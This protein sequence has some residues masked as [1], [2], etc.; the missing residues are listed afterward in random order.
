M[1]TPQSG[2]DYV[3]GNAESEQKR[4]VLQAAILRGW[5]EK[6]LRAA[7]LQAG[8]RVLDIGCGMGDVAF[9]AAELVGPAGISRRS[10]KR[11]R[12]RRRFH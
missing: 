8:M 7:G 5:T 11:E 1:S 12:E 3:L 2:H 10:R 9:L 6:F 4:L